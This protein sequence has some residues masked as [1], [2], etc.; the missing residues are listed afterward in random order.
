MRSQNGPTAADSTHRTLG[1]AD[2]ASACQEPQ[3]FVLGRVK[4]GSVGRARRYRG[5]AQQLPA[6]PAACGRNGS[7]LQPPTRRSL[8]LIP[9]FNVSTGITAAD[10][11][12]RL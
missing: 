2:V 7:T 8:C 11:E 10:S 12:S 5:R 9:T 3:E 4:V 6:R 1:R